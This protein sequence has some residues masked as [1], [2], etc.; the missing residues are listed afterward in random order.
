MSV[1]K[2]LRAKVASSV[3]KIEETE[4]FLW[5]KFLRVGELDYREIEIFSTELWKTDDI[6]LIVKVQGGITPF[7]FNFNKVKNLKLSSKKLALKSKTNPVFFGLGNTSVT[8]INISFDQKLKQLIAVRITEE[9]T[10]IYLKIKGQGEKEASYEL[11]SRLINLEDHL[12]SG[13]KY[14]NSIKGYSLSVKTGAIKDINYYFK[15]PKVIDYLSQLKPE[16]YNIELLSPLTHSITGT[17]VSN[18]KINL[19]DIP[20]STSKINYHKLDIEEDSLYSPFNFTPQIITGALSLYSDLF[21][22]NTNRFSIK[23]PNF[24]APL[25]TDISIFYKGGSSSPAIIESDVEILLVDKINKIIQPRI[26]LSQEEE[27]IFFEKL[28]NY[29][30]EGSKFL[31]TNNNALLADE[32]GLNKT[33][34]ALFAIKFLLMKRE[35]KSV[36]IIANKNSTGDLNIS[37]KTGSFYGWL[38]HLQKFAP[39]LACSC[40]DSESVDINSELGNDSMIKIIPY[41][42]LYKALTSNNL[43]KD[44]VR[45]YDCLIFDDAEN[46]KIYQNN[47]S[48]F[49]DMVSP[50]FCWMLSGMEIKEY[51]DNLL[52]EFKPTVLLSH[53]YNEVRDQLP[54]INETDFW[55]TL[56]KEQQYEYDQLIFLARNSLKEILSTGNPFRFQSQLF[57]FIHQIKQICNFS[58]D[59]IDS[60]KTKLLLSHIHCLKSYK[61]QVIIFSQYDK[62]GTQKL[63]RL[64]DRENIKYKMSSQ[65]MTPGELAREIS[66]FEKD[67]SFTVFLEDSQTMKSS[68][69]VVYAPY[70]IHFDHWWTPISRW[71]LENKVKNNSDKTLTVLN[72]FTKNTIDE[73]ILGILFNK[74]LLDRETSGNIGPDAFS[75]ILNEE[76]WKKIF[77]LDKEEN[78]SQKKKGN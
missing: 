23:I 14:F 66:G 29:Q 78:F 11:T 57:F 73:N 55:L 24:D 53:R 10:S 64:F 49:I 38:G 48:Q 50:N 25:K 74:Q 21:K 20:L 27:Q 45:K 47:F 19:L 43:K 58:S 51:S 16:I 6:T 59:E 18:T 54:G 32:L 1:A 15:P 62:S 37:A 35:I 56:D 70:I 8:N 40:I 77:D 36:L 67:T 76:E 31:A 17:A 69:H 12:L 9:G 61:K 30:I 13:E 26:E 68:T 41:T 4:T 44:I 5:N 65:K 72:Y 22:W 39:E 2:R 33:I 63:T 52:A 7:K 75:K 71:N 46:L 60:N 3:S 42:I 28:S 34:Q